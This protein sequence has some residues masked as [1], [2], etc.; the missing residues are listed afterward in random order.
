[1][2][3]HRLTLENYMGWAAIDVDL[4]KYSGVTAILGAIESDMAHSNGTGKS[5]LIYAIN[6]ALFGT[7]VGKNLDGMIRQG[8]EQTGY[9]VALQFSRDD[10]LYEITRKKKVG[11]PQKT[12]FKNVSTKKAM[13]ISIEEFLH[14]PEVVWQNTVYSA[15]HNLS[16]FVDKTPA[17]RKDILTEIFGMDN[18]L[19]LETKARALSAKSETELATANHDLARLGLELADALDNPDGDVNELTKQ[20]AAAEKDE[21]QHTEQMMALSSQIGEL[22]Q[23]AAVCVSAGREVDALSQAHNRLLQAKEHSEAQWESSRDRLDMVLADLQMAAEVEIDPNAVEAL[24]TQIHTAELARVSVQEQNDEHVKISAEIATVTAQHNQAANEAR[25]C[26][27]RIDRLPK[28]KC[29]LCG[30]TMTAEHLDQHRMEIYAEKTAA[31][32]VVS[33]SQETINNLNIKLHNIRGELAR[34]SAIANSLPDLSRKLIAEQQ[35]VTDR[36]KAVAEISRLVTNAEAELAAHEEEMAK[37][38]IEIEESAKTLSVKKA[39][40]PGLGTIPQERNDLELKRQRYAGSLSEIKRLLDTLKRNRDL[41]HQ[42]LEFKN[43]KKKEIEQQV[44][45]VKAAELQHNIHLE[46]V[47]AFGPSGIPT[48]IL[49]NCLSE[50]QQYMDHYMDLLSDGKIRVT[51]QT[52]KTSASTAKTSETLSIMVSDANGERDITL[53]SGGETVRIYLAIRLALAKLLY[54]KSGHRLGLMV[55]DEIADLDDA[56]LLAFVELLKKIEPEYEQI[57]LVSHIPELKSAFSNS[58]VLTRDVEGNYVP[59]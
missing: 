58:L 24:K 28:D 56:G 21:A 34:L 26:Q 8:A 37:M 42:N 12:T 18:Y 45:A 30:T 52:V 22:D 40:I 55:I 20:I 1:M 4:S 15:Q 43:K 16:A 35:K 14:M 44:V 2:K 39:A 27:D 5:T 3:L 9:R 33:T 41:A 50:L 54:L 31:E 53:Y 10:V 51:F 38:L 23:R 7:G 6:Y 36:D 47:K 25:K 57:L 29:P 17:Q 46:L 11:A 13:G 32:A 48:L 49:E 19:N 59:E